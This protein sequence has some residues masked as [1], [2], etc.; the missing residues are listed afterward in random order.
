MARS[1]L[2][3][4]VSRSI[5][6]TMEPGGH[7]LAV[8]MEDWAKA[9]DDFSP[10]WKPLTS[11]IRRHHGRTFSSEGA[12]TGGGVRTRWR[13]L[14][15]A[16]LARKSP[17]LPILVQTGALRRAMVKGGSGSRVRSTKKSHEVGTRGDVGRIA[18]YH[19]TGTSRMV[20]RPPMQ[21]DADIRAQNSLGG[22]MKDMAQLLIINKRRVN[23]TNRVW[24]A[25]AIAKQGESLKKISRRQTR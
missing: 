3:G 16:T 4:K 18:G 22:A 19:Q 20:A 25:R 9:I 17:G 7:Q 5:S 10:M 6:V 13:P 11:L 24:D 12:A 14:R 8:G 23:L 2:S 15:P 1:P 21:F